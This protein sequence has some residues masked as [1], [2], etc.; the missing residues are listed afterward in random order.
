MWYN[1]MRNIKKEN[2]V[3]NNEDKIFTVEGLKKEF[4]RI[5]WPK[6]FKGE[7][8]NEKLVV[9][10][11]IKVLGFS[12]AFSLLFILCDALTAGIFRLFKI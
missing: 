2:S 6:W 4:K 7:T 9:P 10:T 3:K 1:N 8:K 12:A 11:T 5:R